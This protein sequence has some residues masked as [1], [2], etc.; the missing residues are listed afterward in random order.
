MISPDL[1]AGPFTFVGSGCNICPK[2]EIGAYSML[3]SD[4]MIVGGDH[5]FYEPGKPIIFSGRPPMP[6]TLIGRDCWIG[7]RAIIMAGVK[8]GDGAIVAAGAVVTKDIPPYT[9][10]AGVPAKPIGQR[11]KNLSEVAKHNEMLSRPPQM[12]RYCD[13]KI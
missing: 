9:L 10:A 11:F 4:V 6:K 7:V 13:P 2:V 8:I 12:I 5:Q 1:I 3:A